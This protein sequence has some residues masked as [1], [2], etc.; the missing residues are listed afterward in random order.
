MFQM[1][2]REDKKNDMERQ[3]FSA[4]NSFIYHLKN[5]YFPQSAKKKSE[6]C[7]RLRESG[8]LHNI[9]EKK[10]KKSKGGNTFTRKY[11]SL[12]CKKN[13]TK[14]SKIQKCSLHIL[15]T[16][17]KKPEVPPLPISATNFPQFTEPH[18]QT[19]RI[20]K[21]KQLSIKTNHKVSIE[22]LELI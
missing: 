8:R 5:I 12:L 14:P 4:K 2:W 15:K 9:Q 19:H 10:K 22:T 6:K 11:T 1:I 16:D 20:A 13:S 21:K 3:I 7:L 18:S 17:F